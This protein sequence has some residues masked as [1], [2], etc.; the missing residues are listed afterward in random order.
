MVFLGF[1]W[2][3]VDR[4]QALMRPGAPQQT[5]ISWSVSDFLSPSQSDPAERTAALQI[6][7][8]GNIVPAGLRPALNY[9]S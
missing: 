8:S 9:I 7:V 2:S 1:I 5:D 3:F 4:S 6:D